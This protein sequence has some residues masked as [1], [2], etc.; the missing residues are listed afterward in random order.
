MIQRYSRTEISAIW[1]D[2]HRYLVWLQVEMAVCEELRR[3]CVIPPKDFAELKRKTDQLI[4]E[5]GVEPKRVDH[6]EGI[7]R[8]DVIAFTTAV[9]ER[10]GPI[11][12][13]IHFGLTSSDVV[14]TA[15]SL[16]MQE[17]GAVL[18]KDIEALLKTLR[19]RAQETRELP[20]IGRSHGIFAEPTSFGLKF[21]GWYVEWQR[22]LERLNRALEGVRTGKLSGAVGV[23]PHFGPRFESRV[24]DRLGLER[25]PVSTQVIPRDRHAEFLSTVAICGAS[26]E[27]M[28]IELRH[29]QRS[30]VG[31]VLEGFA[32][33]QKGS[34]AMPHK[35][36]PI[37]SENLTGCARLLRAYAQT[38][39][40]NI[41][42]WHERDISHSSVERIALPDATIL[43]DYALARMNRVLEQ[44]VIRK[45]RIR[46]NLEKAGSTVFSGHFLMALVKAGATREDAYAWVQS[47][48]LASLEGQGEFV[49]LLLK[50]ADVTRLLSPLRIRELGSL[51][52]QLRHVRE[53]YQRALAETQTR[54]KS[55]SPLKAKAKAKLKAKSK[56]KPKAR[57]V[58]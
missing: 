55:S 3:E 5:G 33:G 23:N 51:K 12:R 32:A 22:N 14:D 4:S 20:T 39:L 38:G 26:L 58:Q 37:S 50:H 31:E 53:I 17:V 9:A 29:L 24:L 44:L 48:A 57:A 8:H 2:Q 18:R 42:L 16:V 52:F 56:T 25:E 21:L 49:S 36:N 13:Y 7:T 6:F 54:R 28:A 46:E 19:A 10:I 40:E 1:Q 11:S 34:S 41:A 27:R 35:R 30:E 47:C 45:E 43:L 15:L